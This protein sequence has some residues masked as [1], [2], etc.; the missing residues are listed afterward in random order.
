MS[1][2]A[3][4]LKLFCALLEGVQAAFDFVPK[5]PPPTP[6]ARVRGTLRNALAIMRVMEGQFETR[7]PKQADIDDLRRIRISI[8][9]MLAD[10]WVADGLAETDLDWTSDAA[11]EAAGIVPPARPVRFAGTLKMLIAGLAALE[12]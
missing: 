6:V 10:S 11:A 5:S 4:R 9:A 8:E 1:L 2:S 12:S 7:E 3:E